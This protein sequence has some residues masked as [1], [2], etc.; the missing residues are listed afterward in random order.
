[1]THKITPQDSN[2]RDQNARDNSTS[3]LLE[4]TTKKMTTK[5]ATIKKAKT[6]KATYLSPRQMQS[7]PEMPL[8]VC[9]LGAVDPNQGQGGR[10]HQPRGSHAVQLLYLPND[11]TSKQQLQQTNKQ[12]R[13]YCARQVSQESHVTLSKLI[14]SVNT[15]CTVTR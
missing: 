7:C 6:K 1:M 12:S 14:Y 3:K 8:L 15:W 13:L 11:Q 9:S 4:A 5:S 10:P 2:A